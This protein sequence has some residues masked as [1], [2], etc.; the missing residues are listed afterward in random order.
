[1]NV[2]DY[3]ISPGGNLLQLLRGLVRVDGLH[4]IRISS[5][6]PNLLIPEIVEFVASQEKMCSHF[7]IPLQSGCDEVLHRMR[8]RYNTRL[9]ADLIQKIREAIPDCGIGV[10]VIVGFPGETDE[11]FQT[12]QRFIESLPVSYLHVFTYSERPNTPASKLEGAVEPKVRFQRNKI[13]RS[14]GI[15]KKRDFYQH[16]VGRTLPVLP[17]G[18]VE[19]GSRFGFTENY[20]RVGIPSSVPPNT[21]LPV[22]I[23]GLTNGTCIGRP[24]DQK[25]AA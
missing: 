21:I 25:V 7:H 24:A 22:T 5:I 1:V 23:T 10:D 15:G 8:R 6:E 3:G 19:D 12:T 2:G 9:Y 4:R 14:I 17:E 16:H 13:L 20:V 11:H 18:D